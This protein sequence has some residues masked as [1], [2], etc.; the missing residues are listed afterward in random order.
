[1]D[2]TEHLRLL[3]RRLTDSYLEQTF[4]EAVLLTG[5]AASDDADFFSDLDLLLF[6]DELPPQEIHR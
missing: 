5:S 4:P 6:V 2:A 3:A 1:M